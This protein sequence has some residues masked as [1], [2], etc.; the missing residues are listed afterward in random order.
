MAP[1]VAEL[2]TKPEARP[3]MGRPNR[4]HNTRVAR[5]PIAPIS[6]TSNTSR[7]TDLGLSAS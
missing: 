3:E 4:G 5:W 6:S 1:M 2:D 7:Q